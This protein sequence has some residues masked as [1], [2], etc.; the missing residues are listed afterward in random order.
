MYK[1][2]ILLAAILILAFLGLSALFWALAA[3]RRLSS[4]IADL[5]RERAAR[6]EAQRSLDAAREDADRAASALGEAERSRTSFLSSAG[7]ELRTPLQG[8]FGVLRLFARTEL[9][10][11][12]RRLVNLLEASS[13]QLSRLISD[14]LDPSD[15]CS[16]LD[17]LSPSSFRLGELGSW[18]EPLL[19]SNAEERGLSLK[20]EIEGGERRLFA[21]KDSIAQIVVGL[22]FNALGYAERGGVSVRLFATGRDL[23]IIVADTGPG[24]PERD[25]RS[26]FD[27]FCRDEPVE[28]PGAVGFG[29]GLSTVRTLVDH[30]GGILRSE[31]R[32]GA[33]PVFFVLLPL[34]S[35]ADTGKAPEAAAAP[36]PTVPAPAPAA[37]SGT[38]RPPTFAGRRAIV[39][40]D[41]AINRLYVM[42]VLSDRGFSCVP[43]K[44]GVEAL[45]AYSADPESWD[46]VLM[47]ATMPRMGGVD[48]AERIRAL[49][50]AGS[51]RRVPIVALTAHSS[52]DDRVAYAEAGMDGLLSKPFSEKLFWAEISRALAS[53]GAEGRAPEGDL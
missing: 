36:R 16:C 40:E 45:E 11:E 10:E 20:F 26:P 25:K 9:G 42:R 33:G 37:S 13:C 39:A 46:L 3:R 52:G 51:F 15:P 2:R 30:L 28:C 43:C 32:E 17:P 21:D 8:I 53:S 47:D 31:D 6:A 22:A 18:L 48:A 41:E 7:R 4:A 49:E 12:P 35:T 24:I 1:V 44:D 50:A 38:A 5:A 19:L 27:P 34:P 23:E 29:Q 14:L